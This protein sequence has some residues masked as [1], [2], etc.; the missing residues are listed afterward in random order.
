MDH[1]EISDPNDDVQQYTE[2]NE[3]SSSE[4]QQFTRKSSRGTSH[5]RSND[6]SFG[7]QQPVRNQQKAA[8]QAKMKAPREGSQDDEKRH[9]RTRSPV[10]T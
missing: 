2:P 7:E 1:A 9:G 3:A 4:P 5:F 10:G 8:K 6:A